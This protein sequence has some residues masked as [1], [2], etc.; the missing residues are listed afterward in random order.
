M[1]LRYRTAKGGLGY[2]KYLAAV[3]NKKA[4]G[5]KQLQAESGA[6]RCAGAAERSGFS[7][8]RECLLGNVQFREERDD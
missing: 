1:R 2:H 8:P 5:H 3:L 4:C 7:S 6:S